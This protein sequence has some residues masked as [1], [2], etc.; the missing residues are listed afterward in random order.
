M[1]IQSGAEEVQL[2]SISPSRCCGY[3]LEANGVELVTI[4]Q[5]REDERQFLHRVQVC[6]N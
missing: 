5:H 1:Q 3:E 6:I 2:K 4:T